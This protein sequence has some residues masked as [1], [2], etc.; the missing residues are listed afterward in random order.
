MNGRY[1]AFYRSQVLESSQPTWLFEAS[2]PPP[3]DHPFGAN[4]TKLPPFT[5]KLAS[6]LRIPKFKI[7]YFFAFQDNGDLLPLPDGRGAYVLYGPKNYMVEPD[8]QIDDGPSSERGGVSLNHDYCNTFSFEVL[9]REDVD[10][11]EQSFRSDDIADAALFRHLGIAMKG[12]K[13]FFDGFYALHLSRDG[14]S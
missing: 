9:L 3:V 11:R 2:W 12:G 4:F 13:P 8:Q 10:G 7:T 14:S 6:R 5:A 1:D